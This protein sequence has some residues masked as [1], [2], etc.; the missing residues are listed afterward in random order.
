MEGHGLGTEGG[1][2]GSRLARPRLRDD[3]VD[4][5]GHVRVRKGRAGGDARRAR[6]VASDLGFLDRVGDRLA[7]RLGSEA[8]PGDGPGVARARDGRHGI[9]HSLAVGLE[10][11]R[12]GEL[13]S[14]RA[15]AVGV[16]AVRPDLRDA[17]DGLAG[18][19]RVRER[20]LGG[21]DIV[22]ALAHADGLRRRSQR[23]AA[24]AS[25]FDRVGDQLA[26]R[27][28]RQAF[29]GKRRDVADGLGRRDGIDRLA[30]R[31]E[32]DA[33][34]VLS[35]ARADAVDVVRVVPGLGH[36][37]RARD[38]RVRDRDRAVRAGDGAGVA[39]GVACDRRLF[40]GVDDRRGDAVLVADLR[41]VLEGVARG[42]VARK[43]RDRLHGVPAGVGRDSLAVGHQRDGHM[44]RT[45][46]CVVARPG[47]RDTHRD[48]VDMGVR[49][50]DREALGLVAGDDR[51]VVAVDLRL[52]HGVDHGHA[53]SRRGEAGEGHGRVVGRAELERLAGGS[54]LAVG[55][56]LAVPDL[57]KEGHGRG[58]AAAVAVVRVVP[59]L[60]DA[61]GVGRGRE[62]V[63]DAH[64]LRAGSAVE[65]DGLRVVASGIAGHG[66]LDHAVGDLV[67]VG[68][69]D[70]QVG[71]GSGAVAGD[72]LGLDACARAVRLVEVEG[73]ARRADALGV[74]LVVP[75]LRDRETVDERVVHDRAAALRVRGSSFVGGR[76]LRRVAGR[77]GLSPE[78]GHG[79]G[80]E[81]RVGVDASHIHE[82]VRG[83]A[84]DAAGPAGGR[85]EDERLAGV[86]R[87]GAADAL[88]EMH[89]HGGRTHAGRVVV[90]GP[91]LGNRGRRR[92]RLVD[93]V[94]REA[95]VL[96][97]RDVGR[98]VTVDLGLADGVEDR[99]A[100]L[101][102]GQVGEGRRRVVGRAE[103]ERL[104]GRAS[105]A[106]GAALAVPDLLVESHGHGRAEA[107]DVAA[108][109]PNLRDG[110][111][112]GRGRK[113]VRDGH[114][115]RAARAVELDRVAA[116]VGRVAAD[117]VLDHDVGDLL[118]VRV[119]D[120]QVV[121]GDGRRGA[122][123]RLGLDAGARVV[124]PVEVEGDAR[125][126]DALGIAV[127]VPD[128]RDGQGVDER[129]VHDRAAALRV[130]GRGF[131][132]GRVLRRV[133]GG[134]VFCPE[135]GDGP[136]LI[137]GVLAGRGHVH[138][139]VRRQA[140]DAALPAVRRG[141]REDAARALEGLAAVG[142][143][144]EAHRHGVGTHAG[145]VVV[146]GPSL[147]DRRGRGRGRVGVGDGEA[148]E[149][150]ARDDRSSVACD[151][152]FLD[153]VE[154]SLAFLAG[155]KAACRGRPSVVLGERER[156]DR[157]GVLHV[158]AL[159][160]VPDVLE[161]LDLDARRAEA[162]DVVAVVPDLRDA[163]AGRA[164]RERVRDDHV[165]GTGSA[166]ER[167]ALGGVGR[168]VARLRLFDDGVDDCV[169]GGVRDGQAGPGRG[170]RAGDGL[171]RDA[172]ACIDAVHH[173]VEVEGHARRADALG[174]VAVVP[175]LLDRQG[176]GQAGVGNS[177]IIE[178][179]RGVVAAVGRGV[180]SR[181]GLGHPVGVGAA[182]RVVGG[183]A[184][185]AV[186]ITAPRGRGAC[187]LFGRAVDDGA[188]E[189]ERDL[190]RVVMRGAGRVVRP[191]LG[192]R[193]RDRVDAARVHDRV[194]AGLAG[195]KNRGRV[196]RDGRLDD[197]VD[198]RLAI[199]RGDGQARPARGSGAV[200]G[201][202]HGLRE[203][204]A[205][206][207]GARN[208][209]DKRV[210][211]ARR[212][213]AV[214]VAVV[215][216][217]LRDAD[218]GRCLEGVRDGD[219]DV[220]GRRVDD[221]RAVSRG[222]A[223][224]GL[225]EDGPGDEP[226]AVVGGHVRPLSARGVAGDRAGAAVVD[227]HAAHGAEEVEGHVGAE[228]RARGLGLAGP[229]L[230]RRD[231]DRRWRV[232]VRNRA[233]VRA[234]ACGVARDLALGHAVDDG[235]AVRGFGQ[236]SPGDGPDIALGDDRRDDVCDLFA[237][238]EKRELGQEVSGRRTDAVLVARVGPDLRDRHAGRAG[239]AG[240]RDRE[241]AVRERGDSSLTRVASLDELAARVLADRVGDGLAVRVHG[242]AGEGVLDGPDIRALG[243]GV[244]RR[245][246]GHGLARVDAVGEE[247]EGDGG[248]ARAVHVGGVVPDL[249]DGE[250]RG[251]RYVRVGH[252]D[253]CRAVRER[254]VVAG[255][256]RAVALKR[257]ALGHVVGDCLAVLVGRKA[258]PGDGL[259]S[260]VGRDRLRGVRDLD[261][262]AA[263][264][265]AQRERHVIAQ[266]ILVVCVVPDLQGRDA[267][268]L[269]HVGVREG[270][271]R[272]LVDTLDAC[273]RAARGRDAVAVDA[274]GSLSEQDLAAV[275]DALDG[276]AVGEGAGG[277]VHDG[278]ARVGKPERGRRRV[279]VLLHVV[280]EDHEV[281]RD[282]TLGE[283][284]EGLGHGERVGL[285]RVHDG[286]GIG[287]RIEVALDVVAEDQV[288]EPL[289]DAARGVERDLDEVLAHADLVLGVV[290]VVAG[291]R[292]SLD[293][294]VVARLG[295][296]DLDLALEVGAVG[297]DDRAVGVRERE[298][299]IRERLV[300]VARLEDVERERVQ[301]L[302]LDRRVRERGREGTRAL[303]ADVARVA[304]AARRVDFL[305]DVVDDLAV[306]LDRHVPA[307]RPAVVLGKAAGVADGRVDVARLL[308][309]GIGLDRVDEEVHGDVLRALV[310]ALGRAVGVEVVAVRP[311]LGGRDRAILDRVGVRDDPGV[312]VDLL[313]IGRVVHGE[314]HL[315]H[316]VVDLY[317]VAILGQVVPRVRHVLVVVLAGG[318][319]DRIRDVGAISVFRDLLHC[320][321]LGD[322]D[323]LHVPAQ[324]VVV[325]R[326]VPNLGDRDVHALDK[327]PVHDLAASGRA[328]FPLIRTVHV[329]VV[330]HPVGAVRILDLAHL[331]DVL[332]AVRSVLR[333][334]VGSDVRRRARR[335]ARIEAA[336]AT[337][338]AIR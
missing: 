199:G 133:A 9:G 206:V 138:K 22:R 51:R 48:R 69:I 43:D 276:P 93:V 174:V 167:E 235:F 293:E 129:V 12:R 89:R 305:D 81:D 64:G 144:V 49:V 50:R 212:A 108:V 181:R 2:G 125:R 19:M 233:A 270:V 330:F 101:R 236:A 1:A 307:R 5:L 134:H 304:V 122:G 334:A 214:A 243:V 269:G 238:G 211:D 291:R 299:R 29:V 322:K 169:A 85:G 149:L 213:G 197:R 52:D 274:V 88:I 328:G 191:D 21:P 41:E 60:R 253:R 79:L 202:L 310:A 120:G 183:K 196:A 72:G 333:I 259:V 98:L 163:E 178:G 301:L 308:R 244:V 128:L 95:V 277:R 184:G 156:A 77:H 218:L 46:G 80:L 99:H 338:A 57:L 302:G 315:V 321:S 329:G 61:H 292:R 143:L 31:K 176:I 159:G 74:V 59:D 13:V 241:V 311:D 96:V 151:L 40:D 204:E 281:G 131:V 92:Q 201:D 35:R 246:E 306:L 47:L 324:A 130:R 227:G 331:V 25:L 44:V 115:L 249:G 164:R 309:L 106:V 228:A 283:A 175:D 142:A 116:V 325:V 45:E 26:V 320:R 7:A 313:A 251:R 319:S 20:D 32:R 16:G 27:V 226:A 119:I 182:G 158:G 66:V 127:V 94:E 84:G 285:G 287:F 172:G 275:A 256:A 300:E 190:G 171:G 160:L 215:V 141:D 271:G 38:G 86:L 229:G 3:D 177:F 242:Q 145:R 303:D 53:V 240:V 195:G 30:V 296:R 33:A 146:V 221:G 4:G 224:H 258:G 17:H 173:G 83:Q 317:T 257:R 87:R 91:G 194:D 137:D 180:A 111:G 150:A 165:L 161:D 267:A 75:A 193:E 58:R 55:V 231:I 6:G 208:A 279:A 189:R 154:D 121:P 34:R 63:R 105:L 126:A 179:A 188:P 124:A 67:A 288:V 153:G 261:R 112:V 71:P 234:E 272:V 24:H 262:L 78:V 332:G 140:G 312:I 110:H 198:D 185:E 216:P 107:V 336:V 73:R 335:R 290:P 222:V 232:R 123:D 323:E 36:G 273:H 15:D 264:G 155:G 220:A 255:V 247:T 263:R 254:D 326:V 68:V 337:T 114:G 268:R 39:R 297:A 192:A 65:L 250:A 54:S 166:V 82:L 152:G 147:G 327:V 109:V 260:R 294:R 265:G 266:A 284:R 230:G 135:V 207:K 298:V 245:R 62:D 76:V 11:E 186:G 187:D 316:D 289:E 103:L 168:A 282:L 148:G 280:D 252:G 157:R 237:V 217:D 132:G 10:R 56:G 200:R 170:A 8:G 117:S 113:L 286:E 28:D 162:V 295:K 18:L 219:R 139:L 42:P 203:L 210:R 37:K 205:L 90:V 102:R 136:G 278:L 318:R 14:R 97:A 118:A 239:H 70:R 225:F 209:R 100:V 23:V 104:A 223:G 314:A 248:R